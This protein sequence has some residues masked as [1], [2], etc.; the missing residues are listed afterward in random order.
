LKKRG[1]LHSPPL[2]STLALRQKQ[3]KPLPQTPAPSGDRPG[4]GGQEPRRVARPRAFPRGCAG[5]SAIPECLP[6][7]PGPLGPCHACWDAGVALGCLHQISHQPAA[8]PP[9]HANGTTEPAAPGACGGAGLAGGYAG[10]RHVGGGRQA[11]GKHPSLAFQVC[12]P[13]L[14][15]CWCIF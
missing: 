10:L 5:A 11:P 9:R 4:A 13:Q 8:R 2:P 3:G 12:L 6:E 1:T 15:L 7:M 14:L